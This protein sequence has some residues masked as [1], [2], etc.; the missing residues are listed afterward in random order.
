M[1]L[2]RVCPRGQG[3]L[4]G[5]ISD[6]GSGWVSPLGSLFFFFGHQKILYF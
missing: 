1:S 3:G 6:T 2:E 4:T 5:G